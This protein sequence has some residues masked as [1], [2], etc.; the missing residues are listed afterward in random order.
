VR[1]LLISPNR[2]RFPY[3]VYPIGL[4]YVAGALAPRHEVRILDLCPLEDRE[5][6]P[7]VVAALEGFAPGAVGITVRNVDNTDATALRQFV[8]EVAA[9]VRTIRGAS[10]APVVLGGAGFTL[11]PAEVLAATGAD[12]G[13]VG[14]GERSL[15]LFDALE[16]GR[17]PAA[18][19]G[20]IARGARGAAP[21]PVPAEAFGTRPVP[22][23]NPSLGFYLANSGIMNLQ[24]QRGC[25]FRCVYC[26]YPAIEGACARRRPADEVAREAVALQAAGAR[27]LFVADSVFNGDPRH[28]LAVA[29][30]FRGAGLTIPWGGYFAPLPPPDGFYARMAEAGCTHVEFGTEALSDPMLGR[31]RKAFRRADVLAAH[32]AARAAGL[33]VAHFLI[34]GG[35][36]ETV[37]TLEETFAT[38]ERL[39]DAA[40]FFFCGMRIFRGTELARMARQDGQVAPDDDLLASTFYRPPGLPLADI[41]ARLRARA[42]GRRN[43]VVGDGEERTRQATAR[44]YGRGATGLLWEH[45]VST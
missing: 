27:Y 22:P 42:A 37:E 33:H 29:A 19:P 43:W 15:A 28:A 39:D 31:I 2:L 1:V 34:L 24:T 30:A 45:L 21:A 5:L 6:A 4:D 11:Y 38:A 14:E 41:E 32:R 23:P 36:E 18:L 16:A 44:L 12:Y 25:P 9:L 26:T 13:L 20:V 17:D 3:P 35:P 7:A 40:L 8:G 10:A